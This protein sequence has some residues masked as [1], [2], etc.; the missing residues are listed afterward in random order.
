MPDVLSNTPLDGPPSAHRGTPR[1][2]RA[3]AAL[4]V[5]VAACLVLLPTSSAFAGRLFATGHDLDLHCSVNAFP[6]PAA[7]QCGYVDTA[8]SYVRGG[9]PDPTK[10][11]LILERLDLDFSRALAATFGLGVVPSVSM[12]PRSPAFA[13]E[14]LTTSTYSAILIGSDINCGGCDLNEFGS[15]PDSD[16]IN[17]RTADIATFFNEGG[18]LLYGSGASHGDGNAIDDVYYQSAPLPVGGVTVAPPFT[19]TPEGLALGLTDGDANCCATHNSFT[20]PPAGSSIT[21]AERD[22]AGS[23][24]TL[25]AEGTITGT[26]IF[27]LGLTPATAANPTGTPHTVTAALS[28]QNGPVAG[29]TILFTVTGVSQ[30]PPGARTTDTT[31][32]AAFSYTGNAGGDDTIVACADVDGSGACGADEPSATATKHW[33][34]LPPPPVITSGVVQGAIATFTFTS[35]I[36]GATFECR[37]DAAEFAPCTS[38]FTTGFLAAGPHTFDVRVRDA[39]GNVG[40]PARQ[41]FAAAPVVGSSV[42][43]RDGDGIAD[44]VDNCPDIANPGQADKDKDKIGDVCDQSDASVPPVVGKTVIARVVSGEVFVRFPA[45][46]KPRTRARAAQVPAGTPAGYTPLK[47][48]EVLPVGSIVH[49]VRGRLSLTSASGAIKKGATPTQKAD[50]YDGIFQIRQKA[51]KKPITDLRLRSPD[52][53]KVCGA[54]ARTVAGGSFSAKKSKKSTSKKVAARLFG[55]GKGAFRTS[56]RHSAATVRGTKWLTQ[57]RCD[58]TLTRVTRGVVS[59]FDKTTKKTVTVRAGQSYL[60]RAVRATVKTNKKKTP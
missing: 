34:G 33:V 56:G 46:F 6:A 12:D 28:D 2:S 21:V 11:V 45:G 29:M 47:G 5:S 40:A 48:A 10:P 60:A 18:G 49:A 22:S 38:P 32:A 58:G 1:T 53:K 19:L 43:D 39:A 50:F 31:G 13:A 54:S 30:E 23:S 9:A 27:T 35:T 52:F 8:V 44:T 41:T 16:A 59:V 36:A 42:T 25:F 37:V 26:R 17:A 20:D 51:A 55:D 4:L 15:T 14:P 7:S 24:E 3:L 57:E